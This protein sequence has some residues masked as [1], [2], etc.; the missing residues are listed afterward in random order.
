MN[1]YIQLPS[2]ENNCS[3]EIDAKQ[4][5]NR[6]THSLQRVFVEIQDLWSSAFECRGQ[7][8]YFANYSLCN[9]SN[10][11][12]MEM[13]KLYE[14][15][16]QTREMNLKKLDYIRSQLSAIKKQYSTWK[17]MFASF[18]PHLC[19]SLKESISCTRQFAELCY[20]IVIQ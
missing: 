7:Q 18:A 6:I 15:F 1:L 5:F 20:S 14:L 19:N 8:T 2:E 17:N 9:E 4:A 11:M 10:S 13:D 12:E 16:L 3:H